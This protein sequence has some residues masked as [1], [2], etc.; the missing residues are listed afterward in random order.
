[1]SKQTLLEMTQSILASMDSEEVNSI[2]DTVEANQVALILKGVYYDL[3]ED[4]QL[5]GKE[6]LFQLDPSIDQAAPCVM[7]VP[8]KVT[9]VETI[10]YNY[11]DL[12]GQTPDYR[13]MKLLTFVDFMA[14]QLPTET[15]IVAVQT[16]TSN[17]EEYQF[18][19][20]TD[21]D[22]QYYTSFDDD[23]IIFDAFDNTKD[24]T[25]QKNK[26]MCT[27]RTNL[28][29]LMEDT[30]IPDLDANQ[31]PFYVNKAKTRAFNELKQQINQESAAEARRQKIVQQKR[32]L[33]TPDIPAVYQHAR[34]GKSGFMGADNGDIP[35]NLK[36]GS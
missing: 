15:D 25:L 35:K 23:T 11:T 29:W 1:M 6:L 10:R 12:P 34:Y 33:K 3:V 36:Q 18:W 27:G 4:M 19:Y 14:R 24:T 13:V 2:G 28:T 17:D 30:F 7:H 20:W 16:V 22:P 32:K 5:P 26:S 9:K 21:R 31:F 8:A